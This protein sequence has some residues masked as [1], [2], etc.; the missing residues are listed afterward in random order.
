MNA[1]R[2]MI[3]TLV[4]PIVVALIYF[5]FEGVVRVSIDTVWNGPLNSDEHPWLVLPLAIVLSLVYFAALHLLDGKHENEEEEG[6]GHMPS[7]TLANLAKVL[8]IGFWS[9]LA[10]AALGPEAILVPATMIIGTYAAKRLKAKR[11]DGLSQL[12]VA[13]A[14]IALFTAFFHSYIIGFL[15]VFLVMKQTGAKLSVPLIVVSALSAIIA[16]LTLEV[17]PSHHFLA[18]PDYTWHFSLISLIGVA[19]LVL[20]GFIA[21]Y[22]MY[23]ANKWFD[24]L[25]KLPVMQHWVNKG[26]IAG[27]GL[28]LLYLLGGPLVQFTG[29]EAIAPLFEQ[30]STLGFWGLLWIVII[31]IAAISWSK[32]N[33]YRGG[34]IFPTILVASGLT[35]IAM[36]Y[37]PEL[38]PIYGLIAALVGAFIAN[39]KTRILV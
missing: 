9:L 12:L 17:L 25:H 36:L 19:L 32:A 29:N 2:L 1:A 23:F 6:L 31:K 30:A 10:G 7:P 38:N 3:G 11:G 35:A 28:G 34:V 20:V 14:I 13:S 22:G 4:V 37:I 26:L 18:L 24:T 39:N 15:A 27:V 33:G 5:L 21:T 8:F 16:A